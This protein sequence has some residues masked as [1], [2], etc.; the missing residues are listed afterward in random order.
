[1][2]QAAGAKEEFRAVLA[3][4]AAPPERTQV[5]VRMNRIEGVTAA[6]E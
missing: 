1:M 5:A 6:A 2:W 3:A 4:L